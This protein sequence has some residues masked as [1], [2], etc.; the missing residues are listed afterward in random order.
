MVAIKAHQ[1]DAYLAKLDPRI[2]AILVFGADAGLVSERARKAAET[3]AARDDP[4][5]EILRIEDPDLE[6]DSDRIAVELQTMAMF[7]GRKVVRTTASRR[8]TTNLLKPLLEPGA[9][10]GSLVVEA[11][12][13]RPDEALRKLFEQPG[14]TAAIP[15]YGDEARDLDTVIRADLAQAGLGI[16]AEARQL[17]VSRLGADRALSRGE[18]AKLAL[19]AAGRKTVEVED[20]EAIVG[21]A[22]EQTV[23]AIVMAAASGN[24]TRALAELDRAVAA[25][26]SAQGMIVV[27]QRHMQRL[28][29]LVAGLEA[30]RSFD[31]A[32]RGLRPPL[33]FKEKPLVESQCRQWTLPRLN[34]ALAV[35]ATA[36]R[37]AR[38]SSTL[39]DTIAERLLLEV[40]TLARAGRTARG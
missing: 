40:A 6:Q 33:F 24:A 21:D 18:I 10:V 9:L 27:L 8:V 13:L 28:H 17:L 35:V 26:E 11:G 5:G 7:G 2:V 1:A 4:P 20:V 12:N 22:S 3:M 15:C 31:D 23:G 19:Y 38:L 36:A 34:R 16:T 14:H 29:R 30:G 25:G 32:A 37:D 39:E